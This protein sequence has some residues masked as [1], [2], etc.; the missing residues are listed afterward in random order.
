MEMPIVT[1]FVTDRPPCGLVCQKGLTMS[2]LV[3]VSARH[4][5]AAAALAVL[6]ACTSVQ[7][8]HVPGNW[9]EIGVS[10]NNNV[11]HAIDRDSIRRQGA[12]ATFRDRKTVADPAQEHYIGTPPYK[13]AVGEWELDCGRKTFRLTAQRLLDAK[14]QTLSQSRYSASQMRPMP[15]SRGSASE[16]Q[17]EMVCGQKL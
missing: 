6:A 16:K 4:C 3:C 13:V 2:Y 10:A 17:Y 5:L 1:Q 7:G 15:V 8:P 12:V 11:H 9:Q 14:G